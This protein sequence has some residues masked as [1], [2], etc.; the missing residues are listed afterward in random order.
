MTVVRKR[1]PESGCRKC[2]NALTDENWSEGL[3]KYRRYMCNPCFASRQL[4]YYQKDPEGAKKRYMSRINRISTWDDA[5]KEK[6]RKLGYA[7]RLKKRYGITLEDFEDMKQNQGGKCSICFLE[8][9]SSLG[10][11]KNGVHVDHCHKTG[12]IRGIL[13]E[14]CNRML[15][16]SGDNAWVLRRAADYLLRVDHVKATGG[17]LF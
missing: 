10:R 2:G 8:L 7:R 12:V 9:V 14:N 13:C 1:G 15:G 6:E 4:S 16:M 11:G 17:K 5:R 3:R